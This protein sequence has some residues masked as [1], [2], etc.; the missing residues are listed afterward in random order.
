MTAPP[1]Q[2]DI[3]GGV[4][5]SAPVGFD[6]IIGAP[7]CSTDHAVNGSLSVKYVNPAALMACRWNVFGPNGLA[8][9]VYSRAFI[10]LNA[11]PTGADHFAVGMSDNGGG[12]RGYFQVLTTGKA[13]VHTGTNATAGTVNLPTGA[14]FRAELRTTPGA[15]NGTAEIRWWA[16]PF[17]TDAPDDIATTTTVGTEINGCDFGSMAT[18]PTSPYTFYMDKPAVSTFGWIGAT[19]IGYPRQHDYSAFPIRHLARAA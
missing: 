1:L 4:A 18:F 14:W 19:D 10:W 12:G 16:S 15:A 7:V 2:N 13:G 9:P 5:G 11:I 6:S 3:E 8:I 17:S